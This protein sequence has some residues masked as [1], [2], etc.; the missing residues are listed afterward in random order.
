MPFNNEAQA[1]AAL[2]YGKR[3]NSSDV[4]DSSK[5]KQIPMDLVSRTSHTGQ[6][7]D[8]QRSLAIF[9]GIVEVI[10]HQLDFSKDKE[11]TKVKVRIIDIMVD[12]PSGKVAGT[13]DRNCR[14]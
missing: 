4:K 10:E 12:H 11:I 7:K 3:E 2:K 5:A 13:P 1:Q 8:G 14:T 6:G 9:I